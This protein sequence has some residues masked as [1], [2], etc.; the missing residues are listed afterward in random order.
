MP[1]PTT[2]ADLVIAATHEFDRLWQAVDN[3]RPETRSLPGACETWSVKDL[4]AHVHAWH[5]M[6]I[7]WEEAGRGGKLPAVPADGYTFAET[8]AL[9][10]AIWIRKWAKAS[11]SSK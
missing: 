3:V 10:R 11:G 7:S 1:R 2:K 8:P 5:E 6:T 9:N 4:L